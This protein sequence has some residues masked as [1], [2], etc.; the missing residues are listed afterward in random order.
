MPLT[1]APMR[2]EESFVLVLAMRVHLVWSSLFTFRRRSV[3]LSGRRG[4]LRG[5]PDDDNLLCWIVAPS[6]F[7]PKRGQ[8][9]AVGEVSEPDSEGTVSE[10]AWRS[11]GAH[12]GIPCPFGQGYRGIG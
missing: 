8:R 7:D 6:S 9:E 4:E 12:G 11:F 10:A 2:E 5:S 3:G 1:G